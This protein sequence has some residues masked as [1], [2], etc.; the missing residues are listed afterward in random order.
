MI[1]PVSKKLSEKKEASKK[2]PRHS[3]RRRFCCCRSQLRASRRSCPC[4]RS[5]RRRPC[6]WES[7]GSPWRPLLACT[8]DRLAASVCSDSCSRRSGRGS[9]GAC[10]ICSV[11]GCSR[12]SWTCN[13]HTKTCQTHS[14]GEL[15]SK[16]RVRKETLFVWIPMACILCSIQETGHL[17]GKVWQMWDI[18]CLSRSLDWVTA[19]CGWPGLGGWSLASA[20][21]SP[22][23]LSRLESENGERGLFVPAENWMS[24]VDTMIH[25]MGKTFVLFAKLCGIKR[26]SDK[27][28]PTVCDGTFVGLGQFFFCP[29][30]RENWNHIRELISPQLRDWQWIKIGCWSQK[31]IVAGWDK[32]WVLDFLLMGEGH[33]DVSLLITSD[34]SSRVTLGTRSEMIRNRDRIEDSRQDL[35]MNSV[36]F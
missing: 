28:R 2:R 35:H 33:Y 25:I 30:K 13:L 11:E 22:W 27:T 15:K 23:C 19:H 29:E 20:W 5:S 16:C 9:R 10:R 18:F 1:L 24:C 32:K 36:P 17:S 34:S 7:R 3:P 6:P 12:S 14:R 31:L 26:I 4:S 21:Y 8:R